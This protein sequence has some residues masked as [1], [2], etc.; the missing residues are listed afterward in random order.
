MHSWTEIKLKILLFLV[1]VC[2]KITPREK[3]VMKNR[4]RGEWTGEEKKAALLG[5]TL[6]IVQI[7]FFRQKHR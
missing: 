5:F 3:K 7:L 4:E 2:L 6:A 1:P